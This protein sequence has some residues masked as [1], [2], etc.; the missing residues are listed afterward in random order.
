[1]L[2]VHVCCTEK[3]MDNRQFAMSL[4]KESP[5]ILSSFNTFN[6]DIPWINMDTFHA[7]LS[8]GINRV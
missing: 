4:G 2:T 3:L 7:P 6:T 5:Y 8:V 1:M